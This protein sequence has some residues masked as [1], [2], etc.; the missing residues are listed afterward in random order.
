M[1][2]QKGGTKLRRCGKKKGYYERQRIR[3]AANKMRRAV[4][5][6]HNRE[7]WKGIRDQQKAAAQALPAV[8]STEQPPPP[9]GWDKV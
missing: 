4:K 3:T 9:Q 6:R 7:K 1:G 2:Q 5:R 8:A